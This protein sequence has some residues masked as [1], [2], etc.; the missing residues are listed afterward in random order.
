MK[1]LDQVISEVSSDLKVLPLYDPCD[2]AAGWPQSLCGC[3]LAQP[4]WASV[5][6]STKHTGEIRKHPQLPCAGTVEGVQNHSA[7]SPAEQQPNSRNPRRQPDARRRNLG[8][9]SL[10]GYLRSKTRWYQ[11]NVSAGSGPVSPPPSPPS[12]VSEVTERHARHRLELR[13]SAQVHIQAECLRD[14]QPT[15][16]VT[17]AWAQL[18]KALERSETTIKRKNGQEK[19]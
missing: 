17:A 2:S 4:L 7:R 14:F 19:N 8:R 6:T 12:R 11:I 13:P 5:P 16:V 9:N 3:G 15:L 18:G 10:S 1:V